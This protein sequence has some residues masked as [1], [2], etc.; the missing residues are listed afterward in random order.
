MDSKEP[1]VMVKDGDSDNAKFKFGYISDREAF[2]KLKIGY[3][4]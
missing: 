4:D 1:R 2:Y 3:M